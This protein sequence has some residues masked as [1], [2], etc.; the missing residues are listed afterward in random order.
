[1]LAKLKQNYDGYHFGRGFADIYNPFSLFKAFFFGK[2]DSYWFDNATPSAL[3]EMLANM[4]PI[5]MKDI[6]GVECDA[7]AFNR[8]FDSY[9]SP[10]PVLYQS[11]YLTVKSYD[12]DLEA[13]TLGLPNA[14]VRKGF[15]GCLYQFVTPSRIWTTWNGMH[16]RWPTSASAATMC[17]NRS[18]MH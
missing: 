3:F 2:V 11:G 6:D 12:S 8:P 13:Y 10:L 9:S 4:P 1:M 18:S 17:S 14:E 5:D 15:A 7:S 16:C